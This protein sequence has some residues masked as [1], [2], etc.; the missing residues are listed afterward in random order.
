MR[1]FVRLLVLIALCL[2]V[3][4]LLQEMSNAA[5]RPPLPDIAGGDF[6]FGLRF[7]VSTLVLFAVPTA[8][9]QML[10]H[11]AGNSRALLRAVESP[12][13]YRQKVRY[14]LPVAEAWYVFNGGVSRRES[15]SWE[16]ANQRYAYDFVISDN[17]KLRWARGKSGEHLEDYFCYG[18][19]VLAPAPGEVVET[20]T[21]VPD[22]PRSGSG[23]VDPSTRDFRGNF[24]I[25]RHAEDEY[26]FSAH[27]APGSV[28]V[29]QG[30]LV[31]RGQEIGRCGNSGHST[32]PHL[33]FHVQDRADFFEASGV[34]VAFDD[35]AVNGEVQHSGSYLRRGALVRCVGQSASL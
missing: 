18:E 3:R 6:L 8:R 1:S 14:T 32:E 19:P 23:W 25:I 20:R 5:D 24:V 2:F 22:A 10:R 4:R 15:H 9:R 12:I 21:G 28:R 35:I 7:R 34:P 13:E 33:H 29:K 31:E 27:L 30:E 17:A 16:V 26:S 11:A